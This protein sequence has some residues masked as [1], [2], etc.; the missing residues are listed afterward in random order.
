VYFECVLWIGFIS[1]IFR[2]FFFG[3]FIIS[4]F[5]AKQTLFQIKFIHCFILFFR[6]V[7]AY[8]KSIRGGR[9]PPVSDHL[10]VV[11]IFE[12]QEL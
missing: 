10:P 1:Y 9:Y 5:Y 3:D 2:H 11:A 12:I 6:V 4:V 8:T 7:A